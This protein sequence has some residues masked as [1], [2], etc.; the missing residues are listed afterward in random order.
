MQCYSPTTDNV[1]E[2]VA[3]GHRSPFGC[4]LIVFRAQCPYCS[5]AQICRN[6]LCIVSLTHPI[7][8]KYLYFSYILLYKQG[9]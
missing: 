8:I 1:G 3:L 6:T 7:Y 2:I 4:V 5:G 9:I